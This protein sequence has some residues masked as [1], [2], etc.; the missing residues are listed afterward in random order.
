MSDWAAKLQLA[1]K[2]QK[3][4]SSKS[5]R[6]SPGSKSALPEPFNAS[7][8]LNVLSSR[9]ESVVAAAKAD[10]LGD[11]TRIYRSLDSSSAWTTKGGASG[12]SKRDDD[13]NLLFEVNRS[14]HIQKH[15]KN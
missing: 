5:A 6:T 8:V 7:E 9:Y 4:E 1:K 10:K 13:Y 3:Q 14:I 15:R 12:K 2:P 11:K